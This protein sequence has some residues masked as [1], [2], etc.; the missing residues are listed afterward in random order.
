MKAVWEKRE[1]KRHIYAEEQR[2]RRRE[3]MNT[4]KHTL[5]SHYLPKQRIFYSLTHSPIHILN[6]YIGHF[7]ST[8]FQRWKQC[9][10]GLLLLSVVVICM[11]GNHLLPSEWEQ[12]LTP[13]QMIWSVTLQK[14][15]N[16]GGESKNRFLDCEETRGGRGSHVKTP[17][18]EWNWINRGVRGESLLPA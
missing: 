13:A 3:L 15:W 17:L 16:P 2:R 8:Q 14:P 6:P 1:A 10:W 7:G 18:R 12:R 4:E 9:E 5:T 11:F